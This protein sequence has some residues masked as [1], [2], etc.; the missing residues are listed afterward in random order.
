MPSSPYTST[1]E[2][3]E[4]TTTATPALIYVAEKTSRTTPQPSM[5]GFFSLLLDFVRQVGFQGSYVVTMECSI[6]GRFCFMVSSPESRTVK[7]HRFRHTMV[8]VVL[9]G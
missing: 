4:P 2:T 1:F 3:L 9:G 5:F 6:S 7:L 8:I